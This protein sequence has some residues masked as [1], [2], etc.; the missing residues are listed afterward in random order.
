M[1]FIS[2][3]ETIGKDIV[4]GVEIAAP[5]VGTFVPAVGP[6]FMELATIIS[7]LENKGGAVTNEQ[8]SQL[9]QAIATISAVKQSAT[10]T[11]GPPA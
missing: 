10:P 1:S 7:Q 5:I 2:V 9:V 8:L 6:I 11:A 4:K 3:L